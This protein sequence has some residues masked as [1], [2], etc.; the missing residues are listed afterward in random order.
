MLTSCGKSAGLSNGGK[1]ADNK[2]PIAIPTP[3]PQPQKDNDTVNKTLVA[4]PSPKLIQP[5]KIYNDNIKQSGKDYAYDYMFAIGLIL[6]VIVVGS[7]WIV[8]KKN[9]NPF[10]VVMDLRKNNPYYN[11]LIRDVRHLKDYET[12]FL[13]YPDKRLIEIVGSTFWSE[14]E[15]QAAATE[16]KKREFTSSHIIGSGLVDS[17][18]TCCN[19]ELIFWLNNSTYDVVPGVKKIIKFILAVRGIVV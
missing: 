18:S 6:S 11:I 10:K 7:F 5:I 2:T 15:R 13:T 9:E 16:L 19:K 17:F 3:K 14:I 12:M 4:S 1:R 8:N